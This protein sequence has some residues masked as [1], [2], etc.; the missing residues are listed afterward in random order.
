MIIEEIRENCT[1][2]RTKK[3]S[4][5]RKNS[6]VLLLHSFLEDPVIIQHP[7]ADLILTNRAFIP[8]CNTRRLPFRSQCGERLIPWKDLIRCLGGYITLF[9]PMQCSPQKRSSKAWYRH[10]QSFHRT[11]DPVVPPSLFYACTQTYC[12]ALTR[13]LRAGLRPCFF[14]ETVRSGR[15]VPVLDPGSIA[16]GGTP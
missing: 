8:N 5:P 9:S 4:S 14:G 2:R 10:S 12:G 11:K 15:R 13:L 3:K 7:N 6:C 1:Q 16:M